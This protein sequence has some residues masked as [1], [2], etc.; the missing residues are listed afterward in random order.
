[1]PPRRGSSNLRQGGEMVLAR[2]KRLFQFKNGKG[3]QAVHLC[4]V[5]F[6]AISSL[7]DA[8]SAL[9]QPDFE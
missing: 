7:R 2:W 5:A 4:L 3:S 1:M 6:L 9:S 8:A